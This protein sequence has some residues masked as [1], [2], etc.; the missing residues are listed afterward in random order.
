M[1]RRKIN[2]DVDQ[3]V[4]A[5]WVLRRCMNE[6]GSLGLQK[7]AVVAVVGFSDVPSP[8]LTLLFIMIVVVLVVVVD[9]L[10]SSLLNSLEG[11]SVLNCENMELEGLPALKGVKGAC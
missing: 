5:W 4:D 6:I 8:S 10:L 1:K 11:P 9:A 2:L 3:C 7:L